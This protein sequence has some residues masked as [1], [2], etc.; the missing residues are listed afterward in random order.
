[1]KLI[2]AYQVRSA[3]KEADRCGMNLYFQLNEPTRSDSWV[4][5]FRVRNYTNRGRGVSCPILESMSGMK[6]ALS[7]LN[8]PRGGDFDIR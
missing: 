4:R 8:Y 3:L 1:M 7:D 2:T 5:V 6:I